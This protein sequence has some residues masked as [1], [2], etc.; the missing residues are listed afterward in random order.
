MRTLPVDIQNRID[1]LNQTIYNNANPRM[2]AVIVKA[3][4]NLNIQT[5]RSGSSIGSI[6]IALET[7]ESGDP[8]RIWIAGVVDKQV[9]VNVYNVDGTYTTPDSTFTLAT[10][11]EGAAVRDVAIEFDGAWTEGILI[12]DT[13]PWLFW[14]ERGLTMDKIWAV[15]WDGVDTQPAG[16]EIHSVER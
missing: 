11:E 3:I 14:V 1:L 12:T 2:E 16:T 10:E 4:R 8:Y 5:L 7:D 15:Q 13:V 9:V 6:D